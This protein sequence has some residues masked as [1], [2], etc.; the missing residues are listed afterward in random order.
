[1][2]S[3]RINYGFDN[4]IKFL[5]VSEKTV[6]EEYTPLHLAARFN[7]SCHD[8]SADDPGSESSNGAQQ[9]TASGAEEGHDG[10]ETKTTRRLRRL[11]SIEQVLKFLMD[12][13]K[14][15]VRW[16]CQ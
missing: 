15:D 6:S 13:Q 12:N 5:D 8:H 16:E 1:M 14:V 2:R 4:N 3:I 10:P 9:N 7:P 11:A